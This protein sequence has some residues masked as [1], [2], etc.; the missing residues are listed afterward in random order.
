MKPSSQIKIEDFAK[1]DIRI[2][3]VVSCAKAEGLDKILKLT[4]NFG[5]ELGER[6]ILTGMAM[7]FEP[8]H[9]IGKQFPFLINLKSREIRGHLS[10]GMLMAIGLDDAKKPV[11]LVPEEVVEDGA[12]V[13]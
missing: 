7:W 10:E 6:Q 1:L 12:G 2:G 13:R 5:E 3:T 11:L 4:V 8:E 9:F